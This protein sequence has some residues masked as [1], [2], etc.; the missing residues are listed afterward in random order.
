M[1]TTVPA[2]GRARAG[3]VSCAKASEADNR[4]TAAA[5]ERVFD[6]PQ[7]YPD[8]LRLC[9]HERELVGGT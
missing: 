4:Q 9:S 1:L 7:L 8:L 5:K 3:L 6:M 2:T